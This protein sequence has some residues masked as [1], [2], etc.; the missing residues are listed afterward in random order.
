MARKT[1][2]FLLLTLLAMT[3]LAIALPLLLNKQKKKYSRDLA[4]QACPVCRA[5]T[6]CPPCNCISVAE[7]VADANRTWQ[8]KMAKMDKEL[9]TLKMEQRRS[10]VAKQQEFMNRLGKQD[11][12]RHVMMPF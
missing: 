2:W 4:A 7:A 8:A 10:S 1:S 5:P 3:A 11:L 6:P 12:Q 9:E